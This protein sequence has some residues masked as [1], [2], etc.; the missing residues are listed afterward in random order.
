MKASKYPLEI[1]GCPLSFWYS[2]LSQISDQTAPDFNLLTA[3]RSQDRIDVVI[4]SSL[5]G[6]DVAR[7]SVAI[8]YGVSKSYAPTRNLATY[9]EILFVMPFVVIMFLSKILNQIVFMAE[10]LFSLNVESFSLKTWVIY[11]LIESFRCCIWYHAFLLNPL[12]FDGITSSHFCIAPY[13]C[14][15]SQVRL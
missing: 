10:I 3:A 6:G 4:W 15:L 14:I 11:H 7:L 9:H 1:W 12:K 8:R 5:F 2:T 13:I